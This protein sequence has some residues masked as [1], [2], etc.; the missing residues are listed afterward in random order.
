METAV[1]ATVIQMLWCYTACYS[2]NPKTY[3]IAPYKNLPTLTYIHL[4][5]I[6]YF[7]LTVLAKQVWAR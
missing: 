5:R 2:N 1:L 7:K 3:I 4:M 6:L